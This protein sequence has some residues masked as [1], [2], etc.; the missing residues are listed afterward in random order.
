MAQLAD[1]WH[2]SERDYCKHLMSHQA[3]V[4]LALWDDAT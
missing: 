3:V 2:G 1:E 4:Q